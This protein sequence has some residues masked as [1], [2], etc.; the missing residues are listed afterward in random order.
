M[1]MIPETTPA[2]TPT[3]DLAAALTT[4]AEQLHTVRGLLADVDP[5]Q[6]EVLAE[7]AFV[8][9]VPGALLDVEVWATVTAGELLNP[10]ALAV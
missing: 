10:E 6:A 3:P 2:G 8:E 9:D 7:S 1:T 5:G 4:L